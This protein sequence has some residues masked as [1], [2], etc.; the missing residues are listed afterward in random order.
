MTNI[1]PE[2]Q[3][4]LLKK[5]IDPNRDE[6]IL[7]ARLQELENTIKKCLPEALEKNAPP[8]F[9]ALYFDFCYIYD[10]FYDFL[11]FRPLIGKTIVALGGGFSS[12]K[13]SF[14]NALLGG[15]RL[16]PTAVTPS[17]SVPAY[18]LS[19]TDETARGINIFGASVPMQ[20]ADIR[21]LAHGFGEDEES[22]EAPLG[23]LLRSVFIE[24]PLH[25]Y[26]GIAFLDT[27]GY[28]KPDSAAYS[29]RTDAEIARSQ[30]NASDHILW[31]V[32]A[33]AGIISN[34]D[35][36]FLNDLDK[37]IPKLIIITKADKV[38]SADD[39]S[40][41]TDGVRAALD[42][43]GIRYEDV[44]TYSRRAGADCDRDAVASYLTRLDTGKHD[45]DF[46]YQFKKLF[47]S[48]KN[49]YDEVI[50]E[51]KRRLVGLNR[52]LTHVGDVPEVEEGLASFA[53]EV[54]EKIQEL[55]ETKEAL[56]E[57][58]LDFFTELKG[59]ADEVGIALP[60][61]SEIDLLEDRRTDAAAVVQNLLKQRGL[62][63]DDDILHHMERE[64]RNVSA[65][66]SKLPG[67]ASYKQ[68]ILAHIQ[69]ELA[70]A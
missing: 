61:P 24:T 18:V 63:I 38:P 28:S 57:L 67:G 49:Y 21:T 27:P 59:V 58:Q 5:I 35:L 64:F 7:P 32:P 30:L 4:A 29:A 47:T 2:E 6:R 14:L 40:R 53:R 51:E 9:P 39:L 3:I 11:L 25:S 44:L 41:M 68:E 70:R 22:E 65:E 60:E 37:N 26:A 13:S 19:G 43:K 48:C 1:T 52:A 34:D 12:G 17:T 50:H 15:A 56:K 33:D 31:F 20:I 55:T 42:Q 66:I 16:L 45:A 8:D 69:R 46:A 62:S 10:R 36:D 54:R 23:H